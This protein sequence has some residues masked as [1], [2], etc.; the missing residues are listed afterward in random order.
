MSRG[1]KFFFIAICSMLLYSC[2]NTRYL[3]SG[4]NLYVG[5][6]VKIKEDSLSKSEKKELKTALSS[7]VRPKPNSSFLGLRPKLF[8]YNLAGK[9]KKEKGFRSWMRNKLGEPPVLLSQVDLDYNQSLLSNYSEN[10]GYFNVRV[11]ADTIIKSK[12]AKVNYFVEPHQVFKIRS[13]QF[14]SDSTAVQNEVYKSRRRSLLKKGNAFN[15][16]TIKQERIRIDSRLKEKGYYYFSPDYL[17]VQVDSTVGKNQI[18]LFVKV[19]SEAP[20]VARHPYTIDKVV[21]FADYSLDDTIQQSSWDT[22]TPYNGFTIIDP[23][24]RF[25]PQIYDRTLYFKTGDLY[26]RTNHNLSLNRLV[27]LGTFKFV[28][29]QFLIADST[30]HK[31]N[32]F[33]YLTPDDPKSIRLELLGKTNSASFTGSEININWRNRNF[34]HGAE[35]FTVSAF[36][37]MDFQMSTQNKGFNVFRFGTEAS[38]I[39]PR[40]IAPFKFHSASGFVPRTRASLGY[41]YQNRTKLYALHSFKG[42][43]GYLWKE[44]IRK[45]HQ[46]N[47][48]DI[49]Y[50]SPENVTSLYQEQIRKTLCLYLI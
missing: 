40:I 1:Y 13:V 48:I 9:P 19:K 27:N 49:N 23:N 38:L 42:S 43:F 33:Y 25:R 5:A 50:V 12:K 2:S 35:L 20:S 4:Q 11:K 28:K 36:G 44:D 8:F 31:L 47:I 32:S 34:F 41:E 46:L 30:N 14:V 10:I 17:I 6:D 3:K 29:N 22:I 45:E 26:N 37:G 24:K 18:D 7:L 21:V 16:E 15:L 39:W